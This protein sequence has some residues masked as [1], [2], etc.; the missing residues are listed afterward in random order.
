[1]D[2][3][4]QETRSIINDESSSIQVDIQAGTAGAIRDAPEEL[5]YLSDCEPAIAQEKQAKR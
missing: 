4:N 2:D 5:Y 1:V 3:I